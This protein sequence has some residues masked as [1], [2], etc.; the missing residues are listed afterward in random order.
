MIERRKTSM[1]HLRS[2]LMSISIEFFSSSIGQ[3]VAILENYYRFISCSDIHPI[4]MTFTENTKKTKLNIIALTLIFAFCKKWKLCK[5]FHSDITRKAMTWLHFYQA[6]FIW[7]GTH[8]FAERR[9]CFHGKE[10]LPM[11]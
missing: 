9:P 2:E 11:V 6:P 10:L 4:G 5:S 1:N 8:I 7:N 3:T